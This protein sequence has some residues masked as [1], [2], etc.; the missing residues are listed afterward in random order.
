MDSGFTST[1][2]QSIKSRKALVF[3][4]I[5]IVNMEIYAFKSTSITCTYHY[6]AHGFKMIKDM[7]QGKYQQDVTYLANISKICNNF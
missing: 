1:M 2:Q 7:Q 3:S 5:W 6:Y 4:D